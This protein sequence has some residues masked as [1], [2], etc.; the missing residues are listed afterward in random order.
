[1][2]YIEKENAIIKKLHDTNYDMFDGDR[3]E[4]LD[5]LDSQLNSF[6]E[7]ANTVIRQQQLMPIY[8]AR[9]EG[10]DYR[11]AIQE[12]DTRRHNNH[13]SAISSVNV[14]NRLSKNLG[15]EP[16]AEVDT[17]DRV[18]VAD[19]VGDYIGDVYKTGTKGMDAATYQKDHAYDTAKLNQRR[20]M[21]AAMCD[22]IQMP[23]DD[24]GP[25]PG[26]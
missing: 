16:F 3:D 11:D 1:M 4:A 26:R 20:R 5:F 13:E 14:L 15:L 23:D 21:A 2:T 9:Y 7:Y 22:G 6:P 18:A 10:Q 12:M 24:T 17:K 8:Q 19:F 25:I